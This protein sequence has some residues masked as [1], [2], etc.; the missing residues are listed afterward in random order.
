MLRKMF[1]I[2]NS[3]KKQNCPK[4]KLESVAKVIHRITL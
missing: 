4:Q 1:V 2:A 3:S